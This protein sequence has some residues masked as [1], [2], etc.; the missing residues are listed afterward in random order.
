M[1]CAAAGQQLSIVVDDV[2]CNR[3]NNNSLMI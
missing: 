1:A 2:H 3:K